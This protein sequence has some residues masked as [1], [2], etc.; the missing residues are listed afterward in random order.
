M[1]YITKPFGA[2]AQGVGGGC[3]YPSP[4]YAYVY[5]NMYIRFYEHIMFNI[6][7]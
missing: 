3:Y 1:R 5:I 2:D 6:M 7:F 4:E